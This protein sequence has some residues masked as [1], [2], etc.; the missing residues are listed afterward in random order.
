M[1]IERCFK[2]VYV[3]N[4]F[5]LLRGLV[6]Q[7]TLQKFD[8]PGSESLPEQDSVTIRQ[9]AVKLIQRL[10]KGLNSRVILV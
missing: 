1:R 3:V 6:S 5:P 10:G 4:Q 7:G 2:C 8:L 9:V